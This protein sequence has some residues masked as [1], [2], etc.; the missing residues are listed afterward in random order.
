MTQLHLTL[1]QDE[2]LHLLASNSAN[3]LQKSC[4]Q[5]HPGV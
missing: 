2:I 3:L 1:N 4:G 5:R